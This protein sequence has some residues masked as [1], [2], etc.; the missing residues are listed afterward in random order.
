MDYNIH[1]CYIALIVVI[2]IIFAYYYSSKRNCSNNTVATIVSGER[3]AAY[4]ALAAFQD[5]QNTQR[6]PGGLSSYAATVNSAVKA[7]WSVNGFAP[8]K[9]INDACMRS[10]EGGK[11]LRSASVLAIGQALG[12]RNLIYAAMCVE[13]LHAASLIIDDLPMHDNDDMRRGRAALHKDTSVSVAHMTALTLYSNAMEMLVLQGTWLYD[14]GYSYS[15]AQTVASCADLSRCVGGYGAVAGQYLDSL[16]DRDLGS[17]KQM[18]SK[19]AELKT[20]T[21]F[22][23]AF[24]LGWRFGGGS[25]DMQPIARAAGRDLGVAFQLADDIADCSDDLER[26]K[27]GRPGCNYALRH[28]KEATRLEIASRLTALHEKLHFLGLSGA[29]WNEVTALIMRA[30]SQ[31]SR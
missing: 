26:H 20:A 19:V 3:P 2:L 30:P 18:S 5:T 25:L 17:S 13:E 27:Q 28:G 29:Y 22:E 14:N 21:F 10:M 7:V 31:M 8:I 9:K 6:S 16:T 12:G 4:T 23:L 11:R 15:H 1:A 24:D